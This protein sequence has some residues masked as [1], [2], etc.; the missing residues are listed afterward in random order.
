MA[1]L[2]T[3]QATAKRLV[4][5]CEEGLVRME[6]MEVCC[7]RV[8]PQLSLSRLH[9]DSVRTM[10]AASSAAAMKETERRLKDLKV[11]APGRLE[12]DAQLAGSNSTAPNAT[13]SLLRR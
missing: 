1:E 4:R 12:I 9:T 3:L 5:T 2:T 11:S 6:R 10:Q 8:G 7:Q 13:G